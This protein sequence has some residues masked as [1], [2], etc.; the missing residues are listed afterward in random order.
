MKTYFE[1]TTFVNI[2]IDDDNKKAIVIQNSDKYKVI[3]AITDIETY[4]RLVEECANTSIWT[5]SNETTFNSTLSDLLI[6]VNN[7]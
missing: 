3:S 2:M 5:P 7:A 6:V 4:N 1:N